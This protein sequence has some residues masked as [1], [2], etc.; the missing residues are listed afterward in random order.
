[1]NWEKTEKTKE[2]TP[3]VKYQGNIAF[4]SCQHVYNFGIPPVPPFPRASPEPLLLLRKPF[5]LFLS[6]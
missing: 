5:P 3:A 6:C 2:A 1:M 4:P